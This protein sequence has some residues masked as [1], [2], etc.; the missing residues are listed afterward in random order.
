M[1]Q[2]QTQMFDF[3]KKLANDMIVN[4]DTSFECLFE[5]SKVIEFDF[6]SR[7]NE[8]RICLTYE[9]VD[10]DCESQSTYALSEIS[11]THLNNILKNVKSL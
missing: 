5:D 11:M 2:V 7:D 3:L 6:Y 1:N 8:D 4:S 9:E 10:N